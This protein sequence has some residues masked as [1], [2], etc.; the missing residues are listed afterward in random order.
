MDWKEKFEKGVNQG[1][2]TS[3]KILYKAKDRAKEL[4][5]QGVLAFEIR[6]LEAKHT[7]LLTKLGSKVHELLIDEQRSTVTKKSGGVKEI[8]EEIDQARELLEEKREQKRRGTETGPD[9]G[10]DQQEE[11]SGGA[12]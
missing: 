12:Q 2:D 6:Q 7:D 8:L 9:S 11:D 3:K 5:D 1:L 4:G 10:T